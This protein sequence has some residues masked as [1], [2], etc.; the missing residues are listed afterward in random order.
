MAKHILD[1]AD[2]DYNS[3]DAI[4]DGFMVNELCQTGK[5]RMHDVRQSGFKIHKIARECDSEI[6]K[7]A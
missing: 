2:I 6:K 3:I 1:I 7:T 4:V 5:A